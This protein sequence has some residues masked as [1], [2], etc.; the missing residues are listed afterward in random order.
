MQMS[1]IVPS[2]LDGFF[3][4]YLSAGITFLVSVIALY[5]FTLLYKR[6][7]RR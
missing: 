5:I 4:G 2:W 7:F 6:W 1:P 3:S